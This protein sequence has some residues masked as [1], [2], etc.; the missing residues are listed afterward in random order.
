ME[1][2]SNELLIYIEAHLYDIKVILSNFY[3]Y[4]LWIFAVFIIYKLYKFFN[5]FI[6]GG[7]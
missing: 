6:F 1:V 4:F 2:T 5:R 3:N 7:V